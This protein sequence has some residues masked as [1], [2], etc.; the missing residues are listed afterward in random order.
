MATTILSV[1]RHGPEQRVVAKLSTG[2]TVSFYAKTFDDTKAILRAYE[3]GIAPPDIP[4]GPIDLAIPIVPTPPPPTQ[5]EID[6]A[7]FSVLCIRYKTTKAELA[8]AIGKSTSSDLSSL[9][10]QIK[11]TYKD[12]YAPLIVGLF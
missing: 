1:E 9:T 8:A 10:A 11:S 2:E 3:A 12:A 5:D 6:L 7:A 4:T